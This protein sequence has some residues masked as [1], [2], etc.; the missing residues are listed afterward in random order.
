MRETSRLLLLSAASDL[1]VQLGGLL[2]GHLG[3][4]VGRGD[5]LAEADVLL[6]ELLV[7]RVERVDLADVAPHDRAQRAHLLLVLLDLGQVPRPL[8]LQTRHQRVGPFAFEGEVGRY[9][10]VRN[11]QIVV[12]GHQT[13]Q[14]VLDRVAV[15][16]QQLVVD[17]LL[18]VDA[19]VEDRQ[20]HEDRRE[21]DDDDAVAADGLVGRRLRVHVVVVFEFRRIV[22][23]SVFHNAL[24]VYG[25]NIIKFSHMTAGNG[26][27]AALRCGAGPEGHFTR[28]VIGYFS[29]LYPDM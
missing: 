12:V 13:A 7:E 10:V 1:V 19:V 18:A 24:E 25:T 3:A 8:F 28:L 20:R 15:G 17:H 16:L 14:V 5:L 27:F 4:Q 11:L 6:D 29:P 9:R 2:F 23:L 21:D 22:S 26:N